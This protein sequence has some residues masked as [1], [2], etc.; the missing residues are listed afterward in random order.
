MR[1]AYYNVQYIT[2]RKI[3]SR[4]LSK[5]NI[6]CI[7]PS[8][9]YYTKLKIHRSQVTVNCL[10]S[11]LLFIIEAECF[12]YKTFNSLSG[13][14]ILFW[15]LSQLDILCTSAMKRYYANNNDSPF[16][17]HSFTRVEEFVEAKKTCHW[18]WVNRT[19]VWLFFYSGELGK[20]M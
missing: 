17:C 6:L 14:I 12:I 15:I 18:E 11:N 1:S 9:P 16:T 19:S 5:L 20:K 7:I 3:F 10:F 2:W 13:V 4:I 8:K